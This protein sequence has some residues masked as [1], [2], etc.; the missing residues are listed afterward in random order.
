[1]A[2]T[3]SVRYALHAGAEHL[4][5]PARATQAASRADGVRRPG[6][7][8]KV[9]AGG[10]DLAGERGQF[11]QQRTLGRRRTEDQAPFGPELPG[12]AGIAGQ[13]GVQQVPPGGQRYRRRV[14]PAGELAAGDHARRRVPRVCCRR[15]P[16]AWA[17]ASRPVR[18]ARPHA[19]SGGVA[20]DDRSPGTAAMS[21]R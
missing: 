13:V 12:A 16:A 5:P 14:E 1:V 2:E 8:R 6:G 15:C 10:R 9:G 7:Q 21:C 3:G 19:V 4:Q 18:L 20:R 17:A 11:S